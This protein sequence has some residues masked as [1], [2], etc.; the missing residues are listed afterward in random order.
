MKKLLLF[1]LLLTQSIVSSQTILN[2]SLLNLNKPLE[3]GQLLNAEDVKTHD[4]FVFAS[5]NKNINIIKYNKSLFLSNQFKDTIRN[6]RNKALIGYSF[7]EDG[8]P[9]LYWESEN[10]KNI[11]IIKYN[12]DTKT[13]KPLSF[14]FPANTGTLI[15]TFQKNNKFY[16]LSKEK[17]QDHLLL[18]E[19][20]DGKCEIKM[21]DFSTFLFQNEKGQR[22]PFSALI[23][24]HYPIEKI[25]SEDFSP[26]D[27]TEKKSKMYVLNDRIVLTLDYNTKRT[28]VFNLDFKTLDVTEKIFEM[29]VPQSQST[30]NSFYLENKLFQIS[31]NSEQLLF[32]IQDFDS[33]KSIKNISISKNDSISFKNSPLLLQINDERVQKL[34]TT[35][36]FLK[37]LSTVNSAV[38]A[39]K[40]KQNIFITF[41]GF[42]SYQSVGMSFS[43]GANNNF[44]NVQN[45]TKMVFFDSLLNSNFEFV[46][47]DQTEPLAID[48]LNYFMSKTKNITLVNV[49]KLK[50]FYLLGYYDLA[51]KSYTMRKFTD[52]FMDEG[53]GN[54]IINKAQFSKSIPLD[55]N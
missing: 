23:Q 33:G 9:T 15:T 20:N 2:S 17:D 35:S 54:S 52:G 44:N 10:R 12:L 34:K 8:N 19:F 1:F 50:D 14:D 5:D 51:S 40:N 16:V 27:K 49:L 48:N 36:K 43:Y 32:A 4:V 18:F 25:D 45:D 24:Y 21:F 42:V 30:T 28:Q 22:I 29:P 38:S 31:S 13:S 39:F 53:T 55:R 11:R 26:L 37:Q 7:S 3:G 46:K 41:G 6:E 47:N